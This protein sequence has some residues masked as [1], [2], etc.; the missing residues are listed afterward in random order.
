MA[1]F[2]GRE[3]VLALTIRIGM[4]AFVVACVQAK[5]EKPNQGS[6]KHKRAS[7]NFHKKTHF[8]L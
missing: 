3:N 4:H 8:K 1:A 2:V 6:G 7:R 5:V